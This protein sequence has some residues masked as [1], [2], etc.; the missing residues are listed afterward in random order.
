MALS[1]TLHNVVVW[2]PHS[3]EDKVV[4]LEDRLGLIPFLHGSSSEHHLLLNSLCPVC[5]KRREHDDT[6][7]SGSGQ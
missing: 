6:N 4:I 7:D 3:Q 5:E 2:H 1:V